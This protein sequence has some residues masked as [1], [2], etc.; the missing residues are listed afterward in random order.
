MTKIDITDR[1]VS[2]QLPLGGHS[3]STESLADDLRH[4]N[5]PVEIVLPA[6]QTLLIPDEEFSVSMC[7]A[8]LAAVGMACRPEQ[9]CVFT[10]PVDGIVA[11]MA[12]EKSV[13]DTL[14]EAF[15]QRMY[16]AT[17][18]LA[19]CGLRHGAVLQRV[20]T[21][22]YARVFDDG[23]QFAEVLPVQNEADLRYHLSKLD[24]VYHIYNMELHILGNP[25]GLIDVCK[26][27]FKH[28]TCE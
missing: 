2:I 21:L 17:P 19:P 16:Y 5:C 11:V 7:E 27:V 9:C 12:I 26:P 8:Y 24:S 6:A 14:R 23:L 18:L 22:L 28:L 20:E 3:F 1:K 15:G 13:D 25:A 10:P 4:G